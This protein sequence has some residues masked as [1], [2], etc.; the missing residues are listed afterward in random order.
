MVMKCGEVKRK[1]IGKK[2]LVTLNLIV[3][4]LRKRMKIKLY[5]NIILL[6]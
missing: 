3:I 1:Q 5:A 4:M 2:T 6:T